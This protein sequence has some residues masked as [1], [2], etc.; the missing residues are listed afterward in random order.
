MEGKTLTW[1]WLPAHTKVKVGQTLTTGLERVSL[2]ALDALRY[3]RGTIVCRID[4]S[5][6]VLAMADA[7]TVLHE[8][9]CWSGEQAL[10]GERE[11]GRE[12]DERSWAAIETKRKWLRGEAT[13]EELIATYTAAYIASSNAAWGMTRSAI[14]SATWGATG[15]AAWDAAN[16]AARKATWLTPWT[17]AWDVAWNAASAAAWTEAGDATS[18]EI[19]KATWDAAWDAQNAKLEEML[20]ALLEGERDA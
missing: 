7:T 17:G 10:L 4:P 3:A 8:F 5:G 1:L 6:K 12:P 9:M 20:L 15:R 2:R 18:K 19:W 13:D 11:L 16:T 14:W